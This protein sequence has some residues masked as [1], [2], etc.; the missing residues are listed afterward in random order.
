MSYADN[1]V[2]LAPG[3]HGVDAGDL[4]KIDSL[5]DALQD[6]SEIELDFFNVTRECVFIPNVL[7]LSLELATHHPSCPSHQRGR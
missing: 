2:T 1:D 3:V 7:P 6:V 5:K 4:V